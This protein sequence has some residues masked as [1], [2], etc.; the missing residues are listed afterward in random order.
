MPPTAD[1]SLGLRTSMTYTLTAN[2]HG[3]DKT[4]RTVTMMSGDQTDHKHTNGYYNEAEKKSSK[5]DY[6]YKEPCFFSQRIYANAGKVFNALRQETREELENPYYQ[7]HKNTNKSEKKV[8]IPDIDFE[9]DTEKRLTF[10][11]A[12]EALKCKYSRFV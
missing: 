8:E 9:D 4:M 5:Y 3:N 6:Y 11:L 10:E 1:T 2:T 12:F 7:R